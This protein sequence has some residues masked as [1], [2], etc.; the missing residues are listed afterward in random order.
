MFGEYIHAQMAFHAKALELYTLAHQNVQAINEEE[1]VE[2]STIKPS[3]P[4]VTMHIISPIP[5][6]SSSIK[7]C[8]LGGQ[9][10][11]LPVQELLQ[12]LLQT[13]HLYIHSDK[14]A[15]LATQACTTVF[16]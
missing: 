13:T 6:L 4:T 16:I 1:T 5:S 14:H 15:I 12:E 3:C 8:T 9:A 10:V 11:V 7:A 2:A